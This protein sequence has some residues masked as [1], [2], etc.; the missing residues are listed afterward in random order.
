[1][2]RLWQ[3]SACDIKEVGSVNLDAWKWRISVAC[4]IMEYHKVNIVTMTM[5]AM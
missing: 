4:D 5:M 1:M 3:P 2:S